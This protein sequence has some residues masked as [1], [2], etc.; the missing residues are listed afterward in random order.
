[1]VELWTLFFHLNFQPAPMGAPALQRHQTMSPMSHMTYQS[2]PAGG[3]MG[4]NRFISSQSFSA[5]DHVH[6][7]PLQAGAFAALKSKSYSPDGYQV[8]T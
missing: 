7:A 4:P 5:Y 8:S 1:M 3:F 6:F 2:V